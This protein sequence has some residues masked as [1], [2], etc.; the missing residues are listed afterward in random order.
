M[1]AENSK[2]I[3][4]FKQSADYPA[5]AK[6]LEGKYLTHREVAKGFARSEVTIFNWKKSKG[7]PYLVLPGTTKDAIRY[8]L[9]SVVQ[10][11]EENGLDFDETAIKS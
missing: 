5:N 4:L 3:P 11:A 8:E 9:D 10:W 6:V 1:M 2:V 7:L